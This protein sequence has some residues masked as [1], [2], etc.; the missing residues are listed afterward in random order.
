MS[1]SP[2]KDSGMLGKSSLHRL[3]G[4][5]HWLL[6]ATMQ[7]FYFFGVMCFA[8][9]LPDWLEGRP[10]M[11]SPWGVAT[12]SLFFSAFITALAVSARRSQT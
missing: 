3:I 7:F 5:Q 12:G 1:T 10:L 8:M 2:N 11:L 4:E 6:F 9:G